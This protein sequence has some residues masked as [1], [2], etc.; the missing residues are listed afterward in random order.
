MFRSIIP[1]DDLFFDKFDRIADLT[2]QAAEVLKEIIA[3]DGDIERLARKVKALEHE[4]DEAVHAT[5][6]HLHRTFVTPL[7][8][9]DIHR[10][11]MRLDNILDLTD[12]AA[13][14][15]ALYQ[16]KGVPHEAPKLALVL[17]DSAGVVRE[18][19]RLM[20]RL[21]EGADRILALAVEVNRL[22]NEADQVRRSA[23]ARLFREE[24]DVFELIKWKEILE[25]I[26]GATDRCEDV[27]NILEGLVIENS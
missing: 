14:R 19:V 8:R 7:D 16:P 9:G 25:Y 27:S 20:R 24:G 26:E 21:K 23:M 6:E 17:L 3:G 4:A 11:A 10:L 15:I 22:E 2:V 18:M 12:A 13:S 1:K 5:M